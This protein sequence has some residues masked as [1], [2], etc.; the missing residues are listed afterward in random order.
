MVSLNIEVATIY[1]LME[2]GNT[3]NNSKGL[4]IYWLQFLSAADWRQ[5]ACAIGRSTPIAHRINMTNMLMQ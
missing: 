2:L 5:L 1:K 4:L 3:K